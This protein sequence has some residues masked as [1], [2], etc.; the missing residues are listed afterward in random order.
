MVL[1]YNSLNVSSPGFLWQLSGS[2]V[3]LLYLV[4]P[5][6]LGSSPS[7]LRFMM[8]H[9]LVCSTARGVGRKKGEGHIPLK[10]ENRSYTFHSQTYVQ[11]LVTWS[12][13]HA[14]QA[15]MIKLITSIFAAIF[16]LGQTISCTLFSCT[17]RTYPFLKGENPCTH[18]IGSNSWT[19]ESCLVLSIMF[20]M[21]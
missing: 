6:L 7:P 12:H 18:C 11:N 10:K 9:H 13:L 20:R 4:A 8:A 3:R 2:G 15:G 1:S 19:S 21:T 16:L 5:L 17:H 14:K